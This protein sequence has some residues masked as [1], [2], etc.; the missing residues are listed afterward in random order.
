[1]CTVQRFVFCQHWSEAVNTALSP[2]ALEGSTR[3]LDLRLPARHGETPKKTL[4]NTRCYGALNFSLSQRVTYFLPVK[5]S[6]SLALLRRTDGMMVAKQF[7]RYSPNCYSPER[8]GRSALQLSAYPLNPY[9]ASKISLWS[10]FGD[11]SGS[12]T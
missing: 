7:R 3:S 5:L 10:R 12:M 1:M 4:W 6:I 8:I 11:T 9:S 2:W